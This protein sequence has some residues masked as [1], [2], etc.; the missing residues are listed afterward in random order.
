MLKTIFYLQ[1]NLPISISVSNT[2]YV[3]IIQVLLN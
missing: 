2:F 3:E 1:G